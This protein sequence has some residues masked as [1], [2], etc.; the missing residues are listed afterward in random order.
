MGAVVPKRHARRAVTRVLLKR[1]IRVALGSQP[2]SLQSGLWVV[3]LRAPFDKRQFPSASSDVLKRLVR[4]ELASLVN[5]ASQRLLRKQ[6][7]RT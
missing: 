2:M 3:R 5:G 6:A 1:Q 7:P 4:D